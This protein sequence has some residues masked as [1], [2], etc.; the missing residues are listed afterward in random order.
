MS[1]EVVQQQQQRKPQNLEWRS[2]VLELSSQ[3]RTEREIA[4]ILKGGTGTAHRDIACLNKEVQNNLK[5]HFQERLTIVSK[6]YER[7]K[8][9]V[10]DRLEYCK[11]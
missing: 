4:Q 5:I 7:T 8:P 2:R 6:M 9:G 11:Y 3:G 1:T 10:K